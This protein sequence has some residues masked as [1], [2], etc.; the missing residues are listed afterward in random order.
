MA[1]NSIQDISCLSSLN[2]L[3]FLFVLIFRLWLLILSLILAVCYSDLTHNRLSD[4]EDLFLKSPVKDLH[5]DYNSLTRLPLL[6][7]LTLSPNSLRLSLTHNKLRSVRGEVL[8]PLMRMNSSLSVFCFPLFAGTVDVTHSCFILFY[9]IFPGRDLSYNELT[10]L[11]S[12]VA[13]FR[14]EYLFVDLFVIFIVSESNFFFFAFNRNVAHNN[15]TVLPDVSGISRVFVY[16]LH[17]FFVLFLFIPFFLLFVV[18]Q[19]S[20]QYLSWNFP[21]RN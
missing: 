14:T 1:K 5:L 4:L 18:M 20:T 2:S 19:C 21:S 8:A 7:F 13:S 12:S 3:S 11:P 15:L 10:T 17:S 6:Q 9:F 16:S